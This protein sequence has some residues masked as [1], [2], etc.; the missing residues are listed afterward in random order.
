[1]G[2]TENNMQLV[3]KVDEKKL[4]TNN[5]LENTSEKYN[6]ISDS[7]FRFFGKLTK[8]KFKFDIT[9]QIIYSLSIFS[10]LIICGFLIFYVSSFR[11]SNSNITK[12]SLTQ[13][14][15]FLFLKEIFNFFF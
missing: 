2:G 12:S 14:K 1:M 10:F 5:Y 8:N 7:I 9:N 13:E 11:K 15:N 4:L 6:L 3:I